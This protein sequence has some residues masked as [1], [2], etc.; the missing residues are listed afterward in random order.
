[1]K[2]IL[3]IDDEDK[4]RG[5]LS[6]IIAL[7]GFET[8]QANSCSA[9]IGKIKNEI[10]DIAVCDVK[11]PDGNGINLVKEMKSIQPALEVILLTAYGN[12]P[13]AV[14]G[15]KNGAFDY[16][17]KGDDNNKIIPMINKAI[18]K[19][20]NQKELHI[21]PDKNDYKNDC[22]KQIIGKSE[23]I[24]RSVEYAKKVAKSDTTVLLTGESGTGK[25]VFAAAIHHSGNRAKFPFVALNCSAFSKDL[26]E[27]EL[28]GHKAGA[29]TGAMKEH[30][31]LLE[32]A[33]YG[34]VFLDEIGE[35]PLSLQ[36]KILRVLE[37][38]EFF[39]VG[40]AKPTKVNVRIISATNRDLKHEIAE[41]NFRED[42]YYRLAVFEI[43]L[44]ALRERQKDIVLLAEHFVKN[45]AQKHGFSFLKI[46]D[47]ALN[48]LLKYDWKGNIRELKNVLE[49]A[50]VLSEN[51]I[52]LAEDL[53][54]EIQ[55][56][57]SESFR[58]SAFDLAAVEKMHIQK[59]IRHT[60]GNKTRA[61][62]LLGIGLTTLYRKIAEYEL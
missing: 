30:K 6:R 19:A 27:S 51:N 61:A 14:N 34:T 42:L 13:D 50:V 31:G 60:K 9:A 43:H 11:L 25:E 41:K 2:K 3:I 33:N 29:F 4:L 28:F 40:E 53:P 36:A 55:N 10:F 56:Y 59:V 17:V 24:L 15:M 18:E 57:S 5:L 46:S 49:R 48:F 8:V 39:K 47:E 1:M 58:H 32:A 38:G 35:M 12:I 44:P 22:F 21:P 23:V 45:F 62:E 26:L 20:E 52:I 16:L 54:F 37:T 7:E